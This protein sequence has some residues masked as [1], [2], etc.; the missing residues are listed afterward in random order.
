MVP[1]VSLRFRWLYKDKNLVASQCL[2]QLRLQL[3]SHVCTQS[4][5]QKLNECCGRYWLKTVELVLDPE[6]HNM[7]S[8][9]Q[10]VLGIVC[11]L[12]ASEEAKKFY[13]R[14]HT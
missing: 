2:N 1:A 6:S 10:T 4:N 8:Q 13:R 12:M 7:V 14:E 9:C 11:G 3:H 5:L